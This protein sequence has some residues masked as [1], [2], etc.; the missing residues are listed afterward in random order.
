M[1]T[2]G[3]FKVLDLAVQD[4]LKPQ[5]RYFEVL[6]APACGHFLCFVLI[7]LGLGLTQ[8]TWWVYITQLYYCGWFIPLFIGF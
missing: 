5:Q 1:T 3:R 4:L 7:F 8:H 6:D 2:K